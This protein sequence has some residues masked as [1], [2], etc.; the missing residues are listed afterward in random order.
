MK[1]GY[2][3]KR[4]FKNFTGLGNYARNLLAG[5]AQVHPELGLHLFTPKVSQSQETSFLLESP[6]VLE[7]PRKPWFGWRSWGMGKQAKHMDLFH[8][9]S[10]ELP[11]DLPRSVRSLVTM[12]DLIFMDSPSDFPLVDRTG[13]QLKYKASAER[14][15]CIIAISQAT[16]LRLEHHFNLKG[17]RIEVIP[18][19]LDHAYFSPVSA[20]SIHQ[21]LTAYQLPKDYVLSVGSIIPRKNLGR[22]LEAYLQMND[23]PPLV[24]VGSGGSYWKKL[25]EKYGAHHG[26]KNVLWRP[27]VSHKDLPALYAGAIFSLY[28]STMEGFGM[29]VAESLA[30]GTPVLSS[31]LSSLPEAGGDG[32][33]LVDPFNTQA[34]QAG[35]EELLNNAA[36]RKELS[37]SGRNHVLAFQQS[38]VIE[39]T[40]ALY[41]D[42]LR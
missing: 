41:C 23:A 35:M 29:P 4:A 3:A 40:Y 39:R 13:Y 27:N 2:D 12:H 38:N 6:F 42:L 11:F 34:L 26:F 30:V 15:D 9:L 5:M 22:T 7:T 17:H 18:P 36:L 10:H 33:L 14:A 24:V 1:I 21:V 20:N 16:K 31:N 37:D 19:A 8:G 28:A 25:Q 32:A